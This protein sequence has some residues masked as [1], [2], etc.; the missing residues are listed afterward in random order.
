[1]D[2]HRYVTVELQSLLKSSHR[3]TPEL[4]YQE[5]EPYFGLNVDPESIFRELEHLE[6]RGFISM[7][8]D[9][10]SLTDEGRRIA[11]ET[12]I[13]FSFHE[14]YEISVRSET[15]RTF[16]HR[17]HGELGIVGLT[18]ELQRDFLVEALGRCQQPILDLGCGDGS[19]T[20]IL[21]T[22]SGRALAGIDISQ[23]ALDL[24]SSRFPEIA[25]FRH[26]MDELPD[27]GR[28]VGSFLAVDSLY[29]VQSLEKTI[30]DMAEIVKRKKSRSTEGFGMVMVFSTYGMEGMN[31]ELLKP[32]NNPLGKILR[33]IFPE[34]ALE[35]TDFTCSEL[36]V[37]SGKL[38]LLNQLKD[39]YY[40]ENTAYLFWDRSNEVSLMAKVCQNKLNSRYGYCVRLAEC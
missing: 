3:V 16:L 22:R 4:V 40:R 2:L 28:E 37:W 5:F 18:D 31:T 12:M 39:E 11:H 1:M 35:Y 25:F 9:N 23:D 24:A 27:Y 13:S 30:L 26:S 19:L 14:G 8:N 29:F 15:D 36:D 17:E 32:W 20:N 10:L 21:S 34:K 33:T 38:D 7:E 6:S